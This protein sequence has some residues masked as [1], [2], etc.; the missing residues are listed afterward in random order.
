MW[1]G[2]RRAPRLHKKTSREARDVFLM[3]SKRCDLKQELA[4]FTVLVHF[5][6]G[7]RELAIG[8]CLI[9][10]LAAQIKAIRKDCRCLNFRFS[11]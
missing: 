3:K 2:E 9:S 10:G 8:A 5:L 11:R 4:P 6:F 1:E 7:I